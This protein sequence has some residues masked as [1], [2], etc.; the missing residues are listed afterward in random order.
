KVLSRQGVPAKALWMQCLWASILCLSGH[1][2]DLLNFIVFTVL[3]FYILTIAG[4]FILRKRQPDLPRPYKAFG[5]PVLPAIYIIIASVICIV[6]LYKQTFY[7]G[8]GLLIVLIGLPVY[9]YLKK[10]YPEK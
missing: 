4:I 2:S 1:Y 6:L 5:Y 3:L 8:M 9:A 10:K 7:S